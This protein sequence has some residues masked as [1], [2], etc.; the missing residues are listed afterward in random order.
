MDNNLGGLTFA[1]GWQYQRMAYA[2]ALTLKRFGIPL[3]VVVP[4][5]DYDKELVAKLESV[6]HVL[7]L[8]GQFN[9]FE[10]EAQAYDLSPYD[11][12]FKFDSDM[13][14]PGESYLKDM[15]NLVQNMGIVSGIA[16]TLDGTPSRSNIYRKIET[17]MD[18]PI[19]YSALFGFKK[20][21]AASNF[22]SEVKR[23]FSQWYAL[24]LLSADLPATTDTLYSV[25][26]RTLKLPEPT[27]GL[28]FLHM[29]PGIAG[30]AIPYNW[31]RQI[32]Y[33][34]DAQGRLHV[35]SHQIRIPFHY[36]DKEFLSDSILERLETCL[37]S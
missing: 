33:S 9:R 15:E 28:P 3:T 32:P 36:F 20:C 6:C 14:V 12:T 22:F 18:V 17:A 26:W 2:L 21:Q 4:A 37:Q 8:E 31:T 11:V 19:I 23:L 13:I 16:C 10:Y 35:N 7:P 29:K 5:Y 34:L 24:P 25:A 30:S 1:F 27:Y